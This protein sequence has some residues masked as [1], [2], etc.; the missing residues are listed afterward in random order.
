MIR[1]RINSFSERILPS[2]KKNTKTFAQNFKQQM[3]MFFDYTIGNLVRVKP[4]KERDMRRLI[5]N[6]DDDLIPCHI[7]FGVIS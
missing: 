4:E 7:V 2:A 6:D 3:V 1:M 5:F